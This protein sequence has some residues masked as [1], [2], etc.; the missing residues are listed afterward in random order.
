MTVLRSRGALVVFLA[1]YAAALL[2]LLPAKPLWVDEIIDLGGVRNTDFRGVLNFVPQNAGGV[3]AGYLTDFAMIRWFGY[4]VFL[5]RLPSVFFG[6]L[7]CAGVWIAARQAGL[8]SPLLAALL[9]AAS[10]LVLRY[11]LE[12]R[13][14]AAAAC[15][16]IFATVVF[17]SLVRRPSFA[18]AAGYASLIAVGLY[19]QPYSIFIPVAHLGWLVWTKN[20]SALLS[21]GTAVAAAGLAFL[22]WFVQT[23]AAWQAML[24]SGTRFAV[25][26]RDLAVIPHELT[27]TGY[28]GFALTMVTVV[29]A[30]TFSPLKASDKLFWTLCAAMPLILVPAADAYFGYFLAAR[31]M[32]F[33]LAPISILMAAA[34]D[35][36]RWG[37]V[38]PAALLIAM[39]YEDARWIQRPGEGWESAASQLG[40]AISAPGSC[41][42]FVPSGA[43]TMYV[44]FEPQIRACDDAALATAPTVALAINPGQPA[45]D[46]AAARGKIESSGFRKES[47]VRTADPRI[48]VY[49]REPR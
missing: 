46:I 5:V 33:A 24:D 2:V 6:V 38:L 49:R 14:Y 21:A 36:R 8:S 39:A 10:P 3:P 7:A 44:Y 27:G 28:A 17:V 4:S 23:H 30:L 32:I 1:I 11:N 40:P 22:P 12:A 34:A 25:H 15:A 31:Q 26:A 13:P 37:F 35:I 19:T 47:D 41:A 45:A 29:V 48:E 18:K 42:V 16:S 9:Y 43:R 20:R